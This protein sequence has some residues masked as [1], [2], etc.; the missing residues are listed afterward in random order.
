[1]NL[2]RWLD[3]VSETSKRMEKGK[4]GGRHR[5][6]NCNSLVEHLTKGHAMKSI[7]LWT[8]ILTSLFFAGLAQ[9][10]YQANEKDVLQIRSSLD[11]SEQQGDLKE[12]IQSGKVQQA[13][14]EGQM[15]G[16]TWCSAALIRTGS[17]AS[18]LTANICVD[19]QSTE[20]RYLTNSTSVKRNSAQYSASIPYSLFQRA[21]YREVISA[22]VDEATV[23]TLGAEV[24]DLAEKSPQAG[25]KL[26]IMGFP[27]GLRAKRIAQCKYVGSDISQVVDLDGMERYKLMKE[28]SCGL[29]GS[30][31]G[32]MGGPVI[33]QKGEVVGVLIEMREKS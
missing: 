33:N 14:Q 19:D 28:I 15:P 9:A 5:R 27:R 7:N 30:P 16:A 31:D 17:Q 4:T 26:T 20:N 10:D 11:A 32:M 25:E 3:T 12:A 21:N 18:V 13:M 29:A 1:M 2:S 22:V 24:F 8:P 6:T 23:K